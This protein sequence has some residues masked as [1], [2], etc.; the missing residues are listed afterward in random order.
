MASESEL[1]LSGQHVVNQLVRVIDVDVPVLIPS[2]NL[3][4]ARAVEKSLLEHGFDV[5]RIPFY[6]QEQPA[7][8]SLA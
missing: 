1:V 6:Q 8:R 2:I 4:S 3:L 5:T 7:A